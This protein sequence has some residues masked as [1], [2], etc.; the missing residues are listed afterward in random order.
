MELFLF[1]AQ[2][3]LVVSTK[4][5]KKRTDANDIRLSGFFCK[6]LAEYA[7]ILRS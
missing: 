2:Q 7:I 3:N 5:Q 1:I 4:I 6:H